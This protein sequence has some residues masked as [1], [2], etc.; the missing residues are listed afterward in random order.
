MKIH[1]YFT[2]YRNDKIG[3]NFLIVAHFEGNFVAFMVQCLLPKTH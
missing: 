1:T 3:K 2:Y